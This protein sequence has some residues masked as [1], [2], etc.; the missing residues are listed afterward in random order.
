MQTRE[1]KFR[2]WDKDS[3]K[4]IPGGS[5]MDVSQTL[6]V[7]RWV[8]GMGIFN[9]PDDVEIM[10]Y[11]GLKDKNGVEIYEGDIQT[12]PERAYFG[13]P[14]KFPNKIES[15]EWR[16]ESG[17]WFVQTNHLYRVHARSEVTGNIYENP[18]LIKEKE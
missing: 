1:I 7:D 11:T 5:F 15:V 14:S 10:Q 18:E 6:G 4:M 12:I 16:N 3:K 8:F 17:G 13:R 2:C 9:H